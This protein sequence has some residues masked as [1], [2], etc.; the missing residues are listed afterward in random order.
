MKSRWIWV[1]SLV[2]A[3]SFV[4]VGQQ[5]QKPSLKSQGG[6]FAITEIDKIYVQSFDGNAVRFDL[7][8]SPIKGKS[9]TQGITF[10]SS[11][12]KGK[13]VTAKGGAYLDEATLSGGV[14]VVR[15]SRT[16]S[17]EQIQIGENADR[18]GSKVTL[19]GAFTVT[20]SD[21][22][23]ELKANSGSVQ[24]VE[25]SGDR[26]IQVADLIGNVFVRSDSGSSKRS[27][28]GSRITMREQGSSTLF[29]LG[30]GFTMDSQVSDGGTTSKIHLT[31]SSGTITTESLTGGKAAKMPLL[32]AN[33]KGRV[34]AN[35]K[36]TKSGDTTE[37]DV[38]SDSMLFDKLSS[39]EKQAI[40]KT[41]SA[42]WADLTATLTVK[43]NVDMQMT[44]GPSYSGSGAAETIVIYLNSEMKVLG[45]ELKGGAQLDV[46]P[47]KGGGS[48]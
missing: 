3:T 36:Q 33:L 48:V 13:M 1:L 10:Q 16:I 9:D 37:L 21:N 4:A 23:E 19:P 31:A 39:A 30:A 47:K 46:N 24:L 8:G 35:V 14:K 45:Y 26:K 27:L 44:P 22:S 38:E 5:R 28:T 40:L 12:I 18:K 15:G 32:A 25:S 43:G 29:T 11:R 20:S 34:K 2:A 41:K 6:E 17:S 7:E 42:G